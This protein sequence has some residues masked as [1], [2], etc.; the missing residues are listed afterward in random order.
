[1]KPEH[2]P[3]NETTSVPHLFQD[4]LKL[5]GLGLK[6]ALD[7]SIPTATSFKELR[8]CSA[9]PVFNVLLHAI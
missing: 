8:L 2:K 3:L 9:P 7:Q 4:K 1:M 5:K 6:I